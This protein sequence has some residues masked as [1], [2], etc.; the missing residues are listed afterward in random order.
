MGLVSFKVI[1]KVVG[2]QEI[3]VFSLGIGVKP[4]LEFGL[5]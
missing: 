5:R 3:S 4:H 1:K 2:G